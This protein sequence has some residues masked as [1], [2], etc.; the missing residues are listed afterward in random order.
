M[1]YV[2]YKSLSG[3]V[4]RYS[5]MPSVLATMSIRAAIWGCEVIR[6]ASIGLRA[7]LHRSNT[8]R[9]AKESWNGRKKT[10]YYIHLPVQ[11]SVLQIHRV[12][13]KFLHS[14]NNRD[15]PCLTL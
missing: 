12:S 8:E 10:E 2:N 9:S 6:G 3:L 14:G 1:K 11:S 13:M 5:L 7:Q 4:V 15:S